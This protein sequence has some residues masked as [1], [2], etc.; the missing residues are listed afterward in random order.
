MGRS[1]ADFIRAFNFVK[2]YVK[3]HKK[4]L[5]L[6]PAKD[7]YINSIVRPTPESLPAGTAAI[8]YDTDLNECDKVVSSLIL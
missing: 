8:C 1:E 4:P 6:I 2:R 7:K 5:W 3:F